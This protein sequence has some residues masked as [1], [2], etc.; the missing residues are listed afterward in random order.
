M[1]S[2]A[3]SVAL[4]IADAVDSVLL[5]RPEGGG[6]ERPWESIT[7]Y[8]LE[9][10]AAGSRGATLALRYRFVAGSRFKPRPPDSAPSV[11]PL[12]AP[13][14]P[15]RARGAGAASD[16]GSDSDSEAPEGGG[17]A[18]SPAYSRGGRGADTGGRTLRDYIRREALRLARKSGSLTAGLGALYTKAVP[19]GATAPTPDDLAR[20]LCQPPAKAKAP[21]VGGG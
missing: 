21:T 11:P 1:A 8:T 12:G 5:P 18:P 20:V 19:R 10:G 17:E 14:P 2:E 3:G 15:L 13:Q 7:Q 16:S 9:G 6:P 4:D